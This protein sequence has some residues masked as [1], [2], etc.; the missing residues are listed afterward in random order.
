[1]SEIKELTRVI[2][3][4][5]DDLKK[6]EIGRVVITTQNFDIHTISE[7]DENSKKYYA[8]ESLPKKEIDAINQNKSYQV[9]S[10]VTGYEIEDPI[11][12][13]NFN[14][15]LDDATTGIEINTRI[16]TSGNQRKYHND[17]SFSKTN[18][19]I[20]S[21]AKYLLNLGI[22]SERFK[23]LYQEGVLEENTL[24]RE[25]YKSGAM[26]SRELLECGKFIG[27]ENE[28]FF[29]QEEIKYQNL[30]PTEKFYHN[31]KEAQEREE[32]KPVFEMLEEE[33]FPKK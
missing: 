29:I 20:E 27:A 7:P 25:V 9:L 33:L 17:I 10:L 22:N 6:K 3:E 21:I 14:E 12:K 23:E 30:S 15:I 26:D 18:N 11:V 2:K 8:E 1:M 16:K 28:L 24:L 32:L 19:Q 13:T 4:C 5:L 31:I